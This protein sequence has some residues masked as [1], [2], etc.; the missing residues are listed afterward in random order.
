MKK[1]MIKKEK[2]SVKTLLLGVPVQV[3]SLA[4]CVFITGLVAS[5]SE[6]PTSIVGLLSIIALLLSGLISGFVI[7]K[8]KG[9]GGMLISTLSALLFSL[10]L[11]LVGIIS[12]KGELSF[13][14]LINYVCYVAAAALGA[15]LGK[16]RTSHIKRRKR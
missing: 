3:L 9:E 11:L 14:V 5:A 4:I 1:T 10:I 13:G 7:S 16:H 12:A 2:G 15:L 8:Y 6:N